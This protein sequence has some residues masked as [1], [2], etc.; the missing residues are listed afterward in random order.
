M[1]GLLVALVGTFVF[2]ILMAVSLYAGRSWFHP[3]VAWNGIWFVV[4]AFMCFAQMWLYP[5]SWEALGIFVAG[6]LYFSFGSALGS[7]RWRR[8]SPVSSSPLQVQTVYESDR[9]LLMGLLMLLIIGM[10]FYIRHIMSFSTATPFSP[11]F[12]L[13]VRQGMLDEA[14]NQ[15]RGA[16]VGNLVVLSTFGTLIALAVTQGGRRW[17]L[18]IA[19]L[20]GLAVVYNLLTAAKGGLLS[21]LVGAFAV[22]GLTQK[23]LPVKALIV[24]TMFVLVAFGAITVLRSAVSAGGNISYLEAASLTGQTFL[25]YLTTGPVAFSLYLDGFEVIPEVKGPWEFFI[26]VINYFGSFFPAPNPPGK[27]IEV[28]PGLHGYNTYTIY[29]FYYPHYGLAGVCIFTF[30]IGLIAGAVYKMAQSNQLIWVS[31]YSMLF[32]GVILSILA[33]SLLTALNP[34]IKLALLGLVFTMARRIRLF[35]PTARASRLGTQ[36]LSRA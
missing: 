26:R 8:Q 21:L 32:F 2:G 3:A 4:F 30:F 20:F 31:F 29:F 34:M 7:M 1:S 5:V 23:R 33:D 6:A 11:L 16:F 9:I 19:V 24:L 25:N 15:S 12:F 22:Y 35:D 17:R 28:G 14:Q 10:P 13:E 36:A 18:L 27:F